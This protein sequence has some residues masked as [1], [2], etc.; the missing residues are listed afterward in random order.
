MPARGP[1]L[2]N[3]R[4]CKFDF[5]IDSTDGAAN[6]V[7][8]W[9]TAD[10][11]KSWLLAG[12]SPDGKSPVLVEFPRDGSYGYTFVIRAA[13]A[14][15]APPASGDVPDGW[16]EIDT[17]KP[18]VEIT[19]TTLGAGADAGCLLITWVAQDKN[20]GPT[21]IDLYYA[22]QPAGPWHPIAEK[23]GNAG[24]HRWQ[25]PAGA[26]SRAFIRVKATDRAGNV[27]TCDSPSPVTLKNRPAIKVL[28]VAPVQQ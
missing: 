16:I 13:A 15:S 7:E 8:F 1:A 25:L 18:L 23:I 17:T 28:N 27:T 5:A 4:R 22:A 24:S 19:G 2:M 12:E 10:G 9:A 14:A 26:G 21:P 6:K 11:G 3:A 20:F